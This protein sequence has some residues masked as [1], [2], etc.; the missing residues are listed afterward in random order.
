MVPF[1]LLYLDDKPD[2]LTKYSRWL[3]RAWESLRTAAPLEIHPYSN[4]EQAMTQLRASQWDLF[5]ADLLFGKKEPRGL[6]CISEARADNSNLPIVALSIG[7]GGYE[8]KSRDAGA[9]EYISKA[10]LAESRP[11]EQTREY[12][13][14]KLLSALRKHGR[15]SALIDLSVLRMNEDDVHLVSVVDVIGR[16]EVV[17]CTVQLVGRNCAE[18]RPQYVRSGLSGAAVLRVDCAVDVTPGHVADSKS[19]LVKFASNRQQLLDELSKDLSRFPDELFVKY[20]CDEP[21][22]SGNWHAICANFKEASTLLGWLS[23]QSAA[24]PVNTA[25]TNLFFHSGLA[26]VYRNG[27]SREEDRPMTALHRVLLT[28]SRQS[29]VRQAIREYA[30]LARTHDPDNVFDPDFLE[31]FIVSKRLGHIDEETVSAGTTWCLSH[32]DLHGRNVLV[33]NKGPRLIDPANIDELPWPADLARL[34]ADLFI[35]GWDRGDASHEWSS[36]GEWLRAARAFH[37]NDTATLLSLSA[38]NIA[39][40]AALVWLRENLSS[41]SGEFGT[42]ARTE[43]EF[44]LALGIEYLRCA[45]RH[46][47][48]GTPKKVLGLFC[49]CD[50]MRQAEMR[51]PH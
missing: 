39:T 2:H 44:L 16:A 15:E 48:L 45:Y 30:G 49:A 23:T 5:V 14:D 4:P 22:S 6:E 41:I 20:V 19:L 32:G 27:V 33:T 28:P 43:W 24:D 10:Y 34:A 51:Y 35:S 40:A 11:P 50:A 8:Q 31:T 21:A 38:S 12:L 3:T 18:I 46:Q 42:P 9:D 1:R 29:R 47:E 26:D 36:M 7:N 25:L 37:G 17:N 13:A